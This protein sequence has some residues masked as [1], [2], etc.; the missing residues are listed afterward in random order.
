MV[1]SLLLIA[2][3]VGGE[4]PYRTDQTSIQWNMLTVISWGHSNIKTII[5][6]KT[7]PETIR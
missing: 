4:N 7:T 6:R 3:G 1:Y 2:G 5:A